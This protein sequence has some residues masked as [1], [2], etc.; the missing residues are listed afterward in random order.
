MLNSNNK[1]IA[2]SLKS[3]KRF[4]V[5]P[6]IHYHVNVMKQRL[7]CCISSQQI[8]DARLNQIR[9][10]LL[11][12]IPVAECEACYECEKQKLISPRQ[13]AIKNHL[14]DID[15]I[16]QAIDNHI[17]GKPINM[18]SYDL[19]YSNL[20]N[21][22]CQTCN[23]IDSS[24]I[25]DRQGLSNKFLS[26][27]LDLDIDESATDVYLAGGEP[28]LIKSF[29]RLLRK[30][31]NKNCEIVINTNAT[32]LTEHL[33]A[34]LNRFKNL[35]F[36]ISIDGYGPLN[37]QIRKNSNWNVIVNNLDILA[38]R[39]GGYHIFFINTVVQKDNINSLLELGQWI[40][41][42]NINKWRLSL[43]TNPK[44]FHY[45][46]NENIIIPDTLINL[47]IVKTNIENIT[48]LKKIKEYAE[49]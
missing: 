34:E 43:L 14:A 31:T 33:M 12:N 2:D 41:S 26:S 24:S 29:S 7:V 19:R 47:S 16:E 21:L 23:P 4:C 3:G 10:D 8:N 15:K 18:L 32:I 39:Y 35:S 30:I 37:E 13:R 6:F 22:E 28:F 5:L 1:I 9:S 25:A 45:S 17:A 42:K 11:N 40:E 44:Q 27:E 36:V 20:C 38:N 49:Q 48:L 46:H